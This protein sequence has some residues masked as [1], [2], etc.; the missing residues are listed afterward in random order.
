MIYIFLFVIAV[1]LDRAQL[2]IGKDSYSSKYNGYGAITDVNERNAAAPMAYRVLVPWVFVLLRKIPIIREFRPVGHVYEPLKLISLFA[3]LAILNY[4]F[5]TVAA[6]IFAAIITSTFFFDYWDWAFEAIGIVGAMSGNPYLFI[7]GTILW[8]LSKETAPL[9]PLI[10]F[11]VTGD[12]YISIVGAILC[13][14]SM[15]GVRMYVGKR[16]L[17][18]PRFM[19]N[20][21]WH[22]IMVSL[23]NSPLFLS[24]IVMAMI[25]TFL[26][27]FCF[28]VNPQVYGLY[29]IALLVAGWTMARA[30]ESRVFAGCLIFVAVTLSKFI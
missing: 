12:I 10:F 26:T 28:I 15:L 17:Y 24:E 2:L 16:E 22:D 1:I 8:A 14:V 7:S 20:V 21:N 18:C 9:A 4:F 23:K 30:A 13:A 27:I 5:G 3:I 29:A 19:W 25:I 6:L 11:A